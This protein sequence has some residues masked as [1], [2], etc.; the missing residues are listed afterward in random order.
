MTY[1]KAK[2]QLYSKAYQIIILH[3]N[4]NKK[5]CADILCSLMNLHTKKKITRKQAN[6]LIERSWPDREWNRSR[7]FC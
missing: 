3:P 4:D 7:Y 1:E 2:R 6:A 5:E